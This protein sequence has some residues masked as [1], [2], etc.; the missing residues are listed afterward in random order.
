MTKKLALFAVLLAEA[1]GSW[2]QGGGCG[3]GSGRVEAHDLCLEG[4]VRRDGC[5]PGAGIDSGA[6]RMKIISQRREQA[7]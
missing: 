5:E 7:R 1:I 4:E 3:T 6:L 2:A